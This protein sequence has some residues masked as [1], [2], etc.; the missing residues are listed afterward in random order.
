MG[1]QRGEWGERWDLQDITKGFSTDTVQQQRGAKN[2]GEG[3]Q[4][5]MEA[6]FKDKD[7]ESDFS[8][9]LVLSES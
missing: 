1:V 3:F 9:R 4:I 2:Y 8:L 5:R 6:T 7:V